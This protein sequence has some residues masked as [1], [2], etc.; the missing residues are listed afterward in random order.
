[1]S[2]YWN[3]PRLR[4]REQ[5]ED[6]R[7][8]RQRLEVEAAFVAEKIQA[9]VQPESRYR[10]WDDTIGH[11]RRV[12][13]RDIVILLRSVKGV[14]DIFLQA[15]SQRE[16]GCYTETEASFFQTQEVQLMLNLLQILDNPLQDIPL[17]GVSCILQSLALP[18]VNWRPSGSRRGRRFFMMR[19]GNIVNGDRKRR[20]GK[21][22]EAFCQ[23]LGKWRSLAKSLSIHDSALVAVS[24]YGLLWLCGGDAAG[25]AAEGESG[26]SP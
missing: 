7:T 17:A 4:R 19:C 1:M 23:W 5:E 3:F 10:V 2:A 21:K 13:R 20:C 18:P 24:G 16:I 8:A 12:Q 9:M 6:P 14:S 26:P 22:A 11:Y 25:R 15:L